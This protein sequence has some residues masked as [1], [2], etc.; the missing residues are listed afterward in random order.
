MIKVSADLRED[1]YEKLKTINLTV[2][3]QIRRA[4][5]LYLE[6]HNDTETKLKREREYHLNRISDIEITLK[7][8]KELQELEITNELKQRQIENAFL[9]I[10][11]ELDKRFKTEPLNICLTNP[12]FIK[13][14]SEKLGLERT[15][16]KHYL[17]SKYQ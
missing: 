2:S 3:E 8:L 14:Y 13:Y 11:P 4:T 17:I 1:Q 16:F 12:M 7:K 9:E 10:K 6:T 5:D 15:E